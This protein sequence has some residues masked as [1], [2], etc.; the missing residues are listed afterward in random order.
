MSRVTFSLL[1]L[2]VL[3]ACGSHEQPTST[4]RDTQALQT[5]VVGAWIRNERS[6][7][8]ASG[9]ALN[10]SECGSPDCRESD[11]LL[12]KAGGEAFDL[13]FRSSGAKN[14]SSVV[15]G[16]EIGRAHV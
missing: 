7:N 6:C 10:T 12:L 11:G 16:Q 1:V 2:M 9:S 4:S 3:A 15:G 8:C 5:C 13:V 14:S